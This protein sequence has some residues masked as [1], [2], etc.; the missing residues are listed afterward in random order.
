MKI[1]SRPAPKSAEELP[2]HLTQIQIEQHHRSVGRV[3]KI[4]LQL[5]MDTILEQLRAAGS[6]LAMQELLKSK[7]KIVK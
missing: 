7:I 3:L 1:Q 6:M 4:E 5:D 2:F